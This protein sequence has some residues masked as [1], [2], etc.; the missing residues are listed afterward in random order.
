MG[1]DQVL[2][3][4]IPF[5]LQF[6]RVGTDVFIIVAARSFKTKIMGFRCLSTP[7]DS[8]SAGIL[9]KN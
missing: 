5:T 8:K 1:S 2:A 7:D 4:S 9:L 6:T 3:H